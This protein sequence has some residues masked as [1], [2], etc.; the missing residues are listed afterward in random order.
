M[1][2]DLIVIGAGPAGLSAAIEARRLGLRDVMVLEREAEAGGAPRH[3]GHGGFGMLDLWRWMSGQAYAAALRH[4]ASG[5]DLRTGAAVTAL[6]PDGRVEASTPQG[7]LALQARA[8]LVATGIRET[9]RAGRLIG[10]ARPFGVFTT[11]TLQRFATLEGMLPFRHPVLV[12]S[13]L[14]GLSAL[15][16]LRRHGIRPVALLEDAP[17]PQGPKLMARAVASSFGIGLTA[18]C[19]ALRIEGRDQVSGLTFVQGGETRRIA[20]D[21]VI[22]SGRWL[23]EA[24]LLAPLLPPPESGDWTQARRDI[25]QPGTALYLAGNVRHAVRSSGPVALEG[26]RVAGMIA[27]DLARPR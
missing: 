16:T 12:G 27:A 21:A 10:G 4:R 2:A 1:T 13:E 17:E 11:T 22:V 19:R 14:V 26:G 23:P 20:C 25:R 3:C 9:T 8:V 15:W 7:P 18:G 5:L 24:A 6:H